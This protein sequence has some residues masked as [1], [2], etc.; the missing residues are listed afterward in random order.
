LEMGAHWV[1]LS[2][3]RRS[4]RRSSQPVG[5]V[6]YIFQCDGFLLAMIP[7]GMTLRDL[8]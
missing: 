1:L 4:I 7:F 6:I 8:P 5:A 3:V 2:L